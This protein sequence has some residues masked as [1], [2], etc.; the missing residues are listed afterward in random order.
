MEDSVAKTGQAIP[1]IQ[2]EEDT[3]KFTVSTEAMSILESA[4]PHKKVVV[5]AVA[6]PYRS[7]KSFLA[8]RFLG[9]MK[10]FTVGS[11]V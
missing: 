9:Q 2:L 4:D 3:G 1:F 5:V 11:T 6:G 8:N 7:G 10:G